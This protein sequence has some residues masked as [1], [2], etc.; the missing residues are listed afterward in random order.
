MNRKT[1][2]VYGASGTYNVSIDDSI[3]NALEKQVQY[4]KGLITKIGHRKI[5]VKTFSSEAF[6]TLVTVNLNKLPN[7]KWGYSIFTAN[8]Y[9][10]NFRD[11]HNLK[12]NLLLPTNNCISTI[13]ANILILGLIESYIFIV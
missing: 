7:K 6:D 4:F 12:F 8:Y 5:Q 9:E 3:N 13:F 11:F 2:S 1:Y 10:L